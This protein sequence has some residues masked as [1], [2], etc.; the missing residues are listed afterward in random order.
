M[1]GLGLTTSEALRLA[2]WVEQNE[3]SH[4][5][6]TRLEFNSSAAIQL[7]DFLHDHVTELY[8]VLH[9]PESDRYMIVV[10][11]GGALKVGAEGVLIATPSPDRQDTE[12]EKA[13]AETM[14][15]AIGLSQE[16]VQD[17]LLWVG[18]QN[19]LPAR[20][21]DPGYNYMS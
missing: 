15:H 6:F 16:T 18:A 17:W 9:H 21:P 14:V 5:A 12:N 10:D 3:I 8:F 7:H 1:K 2:G 19:C 13:R 11:G 20:R 4:D